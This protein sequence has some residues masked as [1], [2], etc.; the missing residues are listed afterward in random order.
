VKLQNIPSRPHVQGSAAALRLGSSAR[1]VTDGS[2]LLLVRGLWDQ[3]K[4]GRRI[5][6]QTGRVP[7]FFRSSLMV[8][9]WVTL[10]L[11]G[12]SVMDDLALFQKRGVRRLFG[13]IRVPDA[14]T[15]GRWLRRAGES[16]VPVLDELIW[17]LVRA[18]WAIV[19][20][21]RS[22]TL[23]LDSTVAVR[24]GLK[25]AGA[26]R[27]YNPK[28]KGRPSHHPLIATLAET[29][30]MMGVRWRPGS[31]PAAEGATEWL[32]VLV[33]RLFEAGVEEVT[34]RLDKGFFSR[35]MVDCLESLHV[36]YLLKVPDH[37]WV[38]GRLTGWR[39]S[40]KSEEV[41]K[42][43]ALMIWSGSG[44]L[45][46]ARLL[47]LE[48]RSN[49]RSEEEL[50]ETYRVT[51]RA[52]VLT[53]IPGIHALTAWRGYNAGAVVEQRIEEL[54]QLGAGKTAIDNLDG[55]ALLWQLAAF[56]YQILHV[57]RTTSLYGHWRNAQPNR[58]RN[59]LLRLPAKLTQHSRYGCVNISR[60]EPMRGLLLYALDR[61]ERL[62]A[63]DP[64][65]V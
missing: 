39:P 30:D 22:V 48:W 42:D 61:I 63:P 38:R 9:M 35:A 13:W 65:P 43:P 5:D 18:R 29:G 51:K 27:G 17:Y 57:F 7:G 62:R 15:F 14:T 11:Y 32:P 53:N 52:H 21:P 24:Y 28:K 20:V 64:L 8:E 49:E 41:T 4:L 34:V 56:S 2:G 25:Q 40:Q 58:L 23:V 50:V 45:Y 47:S 36:H 60:D 10:L 6:S 1:G 37:H 59:W 44:S 54:G 46:G 19:G 55:N 31:A 16:L 33:S 3:L 12:G 26:E